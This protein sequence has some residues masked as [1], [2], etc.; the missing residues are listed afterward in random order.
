[1]VFSVIFQGK[2]LGEDRRRIYLYKPD[3]TNYAILNIGSD[4]TLSKSESHPDAGRVLEDML[5]AVSAVVKQ[6]ESV[7]SS[8]SAGNALLSTS[9][10][11]VAQLNLFANASAGTS[12]SRGEGPTPPNPITQSQATRE[13][14]ERVNL[15]NGWFNGQAD[16][17]EVKGITVSTQPSN[18]QGQV[19]YS[20]EHTTDNGISNNNLN[21]VE[22]GYLIKKVTTQS[23]QDAEFSYYI[24]EGGVLYKILY[25]DGQLAGDRGAHPNLN[26]VI[27]EMDALINPN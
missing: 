24:T 6:P 4:G 16:Q 8:S 14:Q 27:R 10:A 25:S 13:Q 3:G 18:G 22:D 19:T 7:D 12:A 2:F 9:M 1:M 26:A 21:T 15:I 23:G 5:N 20:V 17:E 11:Q